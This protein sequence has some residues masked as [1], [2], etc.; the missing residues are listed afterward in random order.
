MAKIKI[1]MEAEVEDSLLPKFDM[2]YLIRYLLCDALAEFQICRKAAEVYVN[3]RYPDEE[4]YSGE[5]RVK[6]IQQVASRVRLAER[7][8]NAAAGGQ[9]SV[10]I[11]EPTPEV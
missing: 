8:R 4:V 1:E 7:L 10:S 2:H 11:V 9:F 6:K 5:E 3:E